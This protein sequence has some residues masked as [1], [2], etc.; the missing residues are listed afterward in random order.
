MFCAFEEKTILLFCRNK[1]LL[2][3]DQISR[4]WSAISSRRKW[5]DTPWRVST[6]TRRKAWQYLGVEQAPGARQRLVELPSWEKCLRWPIA[7]QNSTAFTLK[8]FHFWWGTCDATVRLAK[9]PLVSTVLLRSTRFG[10]SIFIDQENKE[11]APPC[12]LGK[13]IFS[14][15]SPWDRLPFRYT[16]IEWFVRLRY[17]PISIC[18]GKGIE[19]IIFL[20]DLGWSS[21]SR[22]Y[23]LRCFMVVLLIDL[24]ISVFITSEM[25]ET[26][27]CPG[28]FAGGRCLLREQDFA[29]CDS[30]LWIPSSS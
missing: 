29:R 30:L 16:E 27:H 17:L 22:C 8:V 23:A 14:F 28:L 12:L 5:K 18:S 13:P 9:S 25:L 15:L 19:P 20:V 4:G 11:T 10:F 1:C 24:P 6:Q 3:D 7:L 21:L 2:S 26:Q